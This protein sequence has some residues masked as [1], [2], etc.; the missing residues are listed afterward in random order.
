[1]LFRNDKSGIMDRD[2]F[3]KMCFIIPANDLIGSPCHVLHF[4]MHQMI[5]CIMHVEIINDKNSV[6]SKARSDGSHRIV[7]FTPCCKVT[8]AGKEIKRI[9]KIVDPKRQSHVVLVKIQ[10][11]LLL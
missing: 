4:L 6:R 8:K 5:F 7:V 3:V 9:V 10:I 11:V 2:L 1:M